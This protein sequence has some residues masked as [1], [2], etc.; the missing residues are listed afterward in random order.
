[1]K[2][3]IVRKAQRS[4]QTPKNP[5]LSPMSWLR[6]KG[7]WVAWLSLFALACHFA[8]TSDHIDF[9][10]IGF[11][12]QASA[13]SV[14]TTRADGNAP[15][16]PSHEH[17]SKPAADFCAICSSISLALALVL[18]AAVV[19]VSPGSFM[20]RQPRSLVPVGRAAGGHRH[21]SARGPPPA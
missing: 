5:G 8:I 13:I 9:A 12:A 4:S 18:P 11:A 15:P 10:K 17:P 16:A 21:F 20:H 19:V 6:L 2:R 3:N 1:M 14:D 7:R